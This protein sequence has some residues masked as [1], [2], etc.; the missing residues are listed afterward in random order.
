MALGR[1]RSEPPERGAGRRFLDKPKGFLYFIPRFRAPNG[2]RRLGN[3]SISWIALNL[4][5]CPRSLVLRNLLDRF[6]APEA[7]LAASENALVE[8]RGMTP[9][10]V[11]RLRDPDLP[12]AAAAERKHSEERSI[13]ILTRDDPE[14]PGILLE[15]PDP[16]ALLYLRGELRGG[17]DPGIAVVGSRRA[18]PYG[19]EMARALAA[20]I[21]AAG[22]TVVSGMARGID[23]AAHRGALEAGGRTVALLGAGMDRIYPPESRRLAERISL[24]GA[25]LSEFP[26]R[27]PPLAGNFPVRNRLISGMTRGTLVVEAA[28]RSGSLITARLA[29]EQGREVFAVPGNVTRRAALGPNLLIQQGAKLVMRGR[30]VLEEFPGLSLPAEKREAKPKAKGQQAEPTAERQDA[31]PKA[32]RRNGEPEAERI[33]TRI[34]S[35]DPVTLD[36]LA[37]ATGMEPGRLLAALLELEMRDRVK[38]LP[39]GRYLRRRRAK[40]G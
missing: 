39:G 15:L 36:E 2:G 27:T 28:P 3:S 20:E 35:D 23:E 16:P 12:A 9:R 30:D 31:E 14:F 24:S 18:T 7:I 19:L 26:L 6:G 5:L 38:Q 11:R 21:A 1:L 8:V 32:E 17:E 34:P 4:A 33:L 40:L 37:E 29:L 25:L 10:L 22:V 13:R